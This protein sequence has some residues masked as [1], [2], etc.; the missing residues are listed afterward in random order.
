MKDY[1]LEILKKEWFNSSET[2]SVFCC[3]KSIKVEDRELLYQ[4]L[5]KAT[6]KEHKQYYSNRYSDYGNKTN[7]L[8]RLGN[9]NSFNFNHKKMFGY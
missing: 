3:V 4:E 7:S 2:F 8:R 1:L 6:E 5:K 9:R